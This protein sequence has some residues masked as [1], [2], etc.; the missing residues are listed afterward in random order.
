MT[1]APVPE[2]FAVTL[3]FES[4][5]ETVRIVLRGELDLSS[6]PRLIETFDEAC[7]RARGSIAI[8]ATDLAF[9]DS[10]GIS[11]F[12]S[13]AQRCTHDGIALRLVGLRASVRRVFDLTG[14]SDMFDIEPSPST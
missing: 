12:V 14:V 2:A 6:A 3:S 11:A 1:A 5:S 9:C 8:D 4:G 13:A 10:S 7:T